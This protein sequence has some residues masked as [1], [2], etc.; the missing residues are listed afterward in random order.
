[1]SGTAWAET[2]EDPAPVES[3]APVPDPTTL[4]PVESPDPDPIEPVAPLEGDFSGEPDPI[5]DE[6]PTPADDM[7]PV[8][9]S[10]EIPNADQIVADGEVVARDEYSQ[11]YVT[12]DG[13]QLTQFSLTPLNV[14]EN[15]EW[16]PVE[17]SVERTGEWSWLG[18][19]DG[20][21]VEAHPLAPQFAQSASD[22]RQLVMTRDGEEISFSLRGAADSALVL[23][24]G[25]GADAASHVEYRGVLEGTDLL[26]DV[27][28][29]SVKENLKIAAA[30]GAS[31]R[32]SWQ[33]D[34]QAGDLTLKKDS[35]GGI[36]FTSPDGT[37]VFTVPTPVITD[38]SGIE[39]EKDPAEVPLQTAVMRSGDQW[40]ISVT[41][42][43]A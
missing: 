7:V 8:D 15:G 42:D 40:I 34:V 28:A 35:H 14:E 32:T 12:G 20:A 11:T 4:P 31:G 24:A 19:G 25:E 27:T 10:G 29:G 39:G 36:Q 23:N 1:M 37:A 22:P 41:A 17:T 18:I 26:Y 33:W 21:E 5:P 38:S 13:S 3:S 6:Q 43:R 9:V 30:P 16:V 2:G